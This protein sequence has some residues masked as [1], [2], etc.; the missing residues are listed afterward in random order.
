MLHISI[1]GVE[2][3]FG[4]LNGDGTEFWAAV[5]ACPPQLGGVQSAADTALITVEPEVATF[6]FLLDACIVTSR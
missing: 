5:T 4:E 2:A 3:F 1:W 6:Y